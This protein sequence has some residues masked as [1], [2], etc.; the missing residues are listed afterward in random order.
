MASFEVPS[1][2][3]SGLRKTKKVSTPKVGDQT[4][5][6]NGQCLKAS[7]KYEPTCPIL[8]CQKRG[9]EPLPK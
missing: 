1:Q 7:H 4:A 9:G 8:V 5:I 3:L 2:N 6:R